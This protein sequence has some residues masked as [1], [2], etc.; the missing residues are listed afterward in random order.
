MVSLVGSSPQKENGYIL[1]VLHRAE[2]D[3]GFLVSLGIRSSRSFA[4]DRLAHV[5]QSAE[6]V[7]GK[8]EGAGSIPVMGFGSGFLEA[9]N[10]STN[11]Y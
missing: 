6:R 8:D 10:A 11:A 2:A 9:I 1:S 5:A 3:D 7:L 4:Q